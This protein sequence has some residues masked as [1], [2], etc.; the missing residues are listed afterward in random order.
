M[1]L[2][3]GSGVRGVVQPMRTFV[4][5]VRLQEASHVDKGIDRVVSAISSRLTLQTDDEGRRRLIGSTT[6]G[7]A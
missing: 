2:V 1:G 7:R 6:S 3:E 4:L 5:A